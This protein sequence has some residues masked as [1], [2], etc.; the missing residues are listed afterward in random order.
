MRQWFR[1][2]VIRWAVRQIVALYHT[3]PSYGALG[4]YGIEDFSYS[5]DFKEISVIIA[6]RKA[7]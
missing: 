5:S 3:H 4:R 1:R 7:I 6:D 2:R